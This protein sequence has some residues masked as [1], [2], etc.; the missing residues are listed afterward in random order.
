MVHILDDS[1]PKPLKY[2]ECVALC[3]KRIYDICPHG[4]PPGEM[5]I[6]YN[7]NVHECKDNTDSK[8][9]RAIIC[10]F[11]V[12]KSCAVAG[13]RPAG[14]LEREVTAE[15]PVQEVDTVQPS[16]FEQAGAFFAE[17]AYLEKAAVTAFVYLAMELEHYGAPDEL[18][19]LAKQGVKE[20]L[21]HV[22]LMKMLAKIYGAEPQKVA[23][24]PFRLRP[25][26][27]IAEENAR[28]GC[29]RETFGALLAMWQA[30]HAEEE[31]VRRVMERISYE[32]SLHGAL[33][34]KIDEWIQSK[35]TSDEKKR[36]QQAHQEALTII[37]QELQQ[38]QN[39]ALI[40][41]C[42]F[43]N[44]EQS[45]LLYQQLKAE[46]WSE[47]TVVPVSIDSNSEDVTTFA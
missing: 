47:S 1:V 14:L 22:E 21:E 13:R 42:G 24:E 40:R 32:E 45:N 16:E 44:R 7:A 19:Q 3:K 4:R 25:L 11:D 10:K 33:S 30:R 31:A 5:R 35:L 34:W 37:Q 2:E 17:L 46:L 41:Y 38:E 26:V 39:P 36:C 6:Y 8:G 15:F 23:V 20:E 12:K 43:P 9:T 18:I 29:I 28:E 27:E